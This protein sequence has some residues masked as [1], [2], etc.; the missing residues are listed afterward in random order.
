M[1]IIMSSSFSIHHQ[2]PSFI[3]NESNIPSEPKSGVESASLSSQQAI[4]PEQ[5]SGEIKFKRQGTMTV[6]KVIFKSS[7]SVKP[8]FRALGNMIAAGITYPFSNKTSQA[9]KANMAHAGYELGRI[10][11][12]SYFGQDLAVE[13]SRNIARKEVLAS[14]KDYEASLELLEHCKMLDFPTVTIDP[15]KN[16]Q[17]QISDGICAGI[18]LD[19]AHRH[20]VKGES[21]IDIMKSNEKGA[22]A[23]AAANQAIYELLG[24]K[25]QKIDQVLQSTLSHLEKVS[26][27]QGGHELSK[28]NV[29][30][31][32]RTMSNLDTEIQMSSDFQKFRTETGLDDPIPRDTTSLNYSMGR[33]FTEE[34][35]KA[36]DLEAAGKQHEFLA[37]NPKTKEWE[38]S[39]FTKFQEAAVKKINAQF[40]D[41]LMENPKQHSQL[42]EKRNQDLNALKWTVGLLELKQDVRRSKAQPSVPL[43]ESKL[44]R[45]WQA[46]RD[47][48]IKI[49]GKKTERDKW[50]SFSA[51][52]NPLLRQTISNFYL[53]E[54]NR[55]TY[56]AVATARQLKLVSVADILGDSSLH[57]GDASFLQ[58]LPKLPA[59]VY[60]IDLKTSAVGH[61]ITYIKEEDGKGYILDPNGYALACRDPD[62]AI[63]LLQ[64]VLSMY[65]EPK[66]KAPLS[67]KNDPNHQL[68][69][70]RIESR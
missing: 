18:R 6:A 61:A 20:L 55:A 22:P 34:R 21:I 53:E 44:D 3:P 48:A 4:Q 70:S 25:E 41:A 7:Q 67:T 27:G 58:N 50:G 57:K 68:V 30:T 13:S 65:D 51:I 64:K 26:Q 43:S 28:V 11:A 62:H 24:A 60:A 52:S 69:I 10:W 46:I 14:G 23:E 31:V 39:D 40:Y 9:F 17:S 47:K 54:L 45:A 36:R 29:Q 63:E 16:P 38:I 66:T 56:G 33:L 35:T 8:F 32:L 1:V 19:I 2:Q 15:S 59:G 12:N 42:L 37:R 5:S 49:F